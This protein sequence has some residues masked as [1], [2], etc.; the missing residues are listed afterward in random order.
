MFRPFAPLFAVLLA[1]GVM[2]ASGS[3]PE[4]YR[5]QRLRVERRDAKLRSVPEVPPAGQRLKVLIDTDAHNEIDDVWAL[6]LALLH[7]ERFEVVGLVAANYDNHNEGAGPASVARSAATIHEVLAQCGLSGRYPVKLGSPPLQYQFEPSSSEGVDFIV[8]SAMAASPE[9]PLWII[10][11]GAATNVA[12][13]YLQEPRIAE[14]VVVFWHGRTAWPEKATNFNVHGDVR[15]A[16]LLFHSDLPLVLFD[17]GSDLYCPMEESAAW[18]LASP[19]GKYL[20]DYR[21]RGEW[22]QSAKKGFYDLGDIAALLDPALGKWETVDC[23][24][25]G[26]DLTYHF[27]GN[28]GRILRCFAID[29]DGT[30]ARF[31]A[32]VSAARP[33]SRPS[34]ARV[35]FDTDVGADVDDAGALAMLHALAAQGEV[36]VLAMGVVNGHPL[37]VPFVDALN[38][39]YGRPDLPVGTVRQG[40]PFASD[41]FMAPVVA[42]Y[43]HD[44]TQDQAPDV[45]ALYRRVL[46]AQPDHSV[47]LVAVGPATNISRLLASPPDDLSP[48]DGATLVGRKVRLY[49]AGGNGDG[50]LPHGRPGFNY[51]MDLASARHELAALP[52]TFPTVQAG[53]SGW[54]ITLGNCLQDLPSDHLLRR[55]YASYFRGQDDLNRPTWDL[56]RVLYACRPE[57]QELFD[58]S[59]SGDL[60]LDDSGQLHWSSQPMRQRAYAYV[61]DVDAVVGQLTALMRHRPP[62]R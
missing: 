3:E 32:S 29:R 13:A 52:E 25:V 59:P 56:L 44:L 21:Y 42:A 27:R 46:A 50:H 23:P 45:V 20:H 48:L 61:R 47:T 10:A 39:W 17:T 11:L 60:T 7:P 35:I 12:S 57:A 16:R 8:A 14:R 37:A 54:S 62:A 31:G 19:L 55:A 15:A 18:A 2:R 40:A 9:E 24:E 43:P 22:Y 30:F 28:R 41:T 51:H 49:S 5:E 26:W 6:A 4:P 1:A 33:A 36:E 53:G 58:T 34:P 38:T